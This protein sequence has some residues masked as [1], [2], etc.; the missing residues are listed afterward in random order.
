[1][2]ITFTQISYN[3]LLNEGAHLFRQHWEEIA[4]HKAERPL[5]VNH[6]GFFQQESQGRLNVFA[7]YEEQTLVGYAVFVFSLSSHYSIPVA[8]NDAFYLQPEFRKGWT[9]L[10]FIKYCVK[11]LQATQA[12]QLIWRTKSH[13]S[14]ASLLERCGL[15]E[16]DVCY[17]MLLAGGKNG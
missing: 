8:V 9:A 2:A 10:K 17:S 11:K 4:L 14:F 13:Q 12:K 15:C 6:A 16:D 3:A 5:N 1:M 7:V